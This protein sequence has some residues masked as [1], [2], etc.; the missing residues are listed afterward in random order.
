MGAEGRGYG[1]GGERTLRDVAEEG[2]R[3]ELGS[4]G[5]VDDVE[6]EGGGVR[7]RGREWGDDEV[8]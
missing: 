6:V 1:K 8:G 3:E 2:R 4:S 7:G 5:G